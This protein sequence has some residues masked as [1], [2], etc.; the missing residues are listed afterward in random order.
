MTALKNVLGLTVAAGAL[1]TATAAFADGGGHKGHGHDGPK[2]GDKPAAA[3]E[4]AGKGAAAALALIAGGA[5]IVV[6]RRRR[7]S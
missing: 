5:A 7:Q 3:P 2:G 1:L 6:S 4:L